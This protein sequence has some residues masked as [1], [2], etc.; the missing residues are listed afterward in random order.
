MMRWTTVSAAVIAALAIVYS[1]SAAMAAKKAQT[2]PPPSMFK[3]C[4]EKSG[5]QYYESAGKGHCLQQS[6]RSQEAF[7]QCVYAQ[8][9][10]TQSI[11]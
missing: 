3:E 4:C 8:G 11:K 10:R 7:Q 9:V 1:A 5:A 6:E 2:A